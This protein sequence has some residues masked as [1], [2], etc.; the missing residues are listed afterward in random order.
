MCRSPAVPSARSWSA[1][2]ALGCTPDDSPA[3][4]CK[5]PCRAGQADAVNKGG[6]APGRHP[7][8]R[9]LARIAPAPAQTRRNAAITRCGHLRIASEIAGHLVEGRLRHAILVSGSMISNNRR[10]AEVADARAARWRARAASARYRTARA[11]GRSRSQRFLPPAGSAEDA[12]RPSSLAYHRKWRAD[13]LNECWLIPA[14]TADGDHDRLALT[15]RTR[16]PSQT[17]SVLPL[18]GV[19]A[20]LR[21]G[22][23][24]VASASASLR[25]VL[26]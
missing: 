13:I 14:I 3:G 25:P 6:L 7:Q 12:T 20:A 22:P 2:T 10:R 17:R 26:P 1:V 4:F 16:R 19:T 9:A 21:I 8:V 18:S 24:R 5:R 11:R 15:E 23:E